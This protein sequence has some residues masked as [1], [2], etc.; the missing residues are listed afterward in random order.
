MD[1]RKLLPVLLAVMVAA[2][3]CAT[4]APAAATVNGLKIAESEV[5]EELDAVRADPNFRELV[6]RQGDEFRGEQRRN[7]LTALIRQAV[8]RQQAEEMGVE[9]TEPQIDEL[10]QSYI[11][12]VG[13]E[14]PFQQLMEENN[15]DMER[16]RLLAERQLRETELMRA[17]TADLDVA[18]EQIR[19]FYES[20]IGAFEE[21]RLRVA[22]LPTGEEAE[23]FMNDVAGDA[24]F[25]ELARER[26]IDQ[27]AENGG[28]LGWVATGAL[29]GE[30]LAELE[31]VPEGGLAGPR[32]GQGGFEVFQLL[33]RRP[34]PMEEVR[35][36]IADELLR[37]DREQ[38]YGV[39]L[40]EQLQRAQI[41]VNPKYGVFDPDAMQV[42]GAPDDL[43]D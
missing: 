42:V 39:W 3:S 31:R 27:A 7:I 40:V 15:I 35:D 37:Q 9:V 33:E 11:R 16:V 1:L 8:A 17:V 13:G 21:L 20:N 34:R 18:D 2:S 12:E 22:T 32:Q 14:E 38:E 28:D 29:D 19:E 25:P 23:A 41:V 10:V 24:D 43:P 5:E 6:R 26:S 30:L 36:Q 4:L